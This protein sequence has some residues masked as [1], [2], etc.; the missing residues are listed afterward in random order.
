MPRMKLSA[1][2]T[3]VAP[4]GIALVCAASALA[5]ACSPWSDRPSRAPA[6][7]ELRFVRPSAAEPVLLNEDLVLYFSGEVDR[8]SVTRASIQIRSGSDE[9]RGSLQVDGDRVRFV[10]AP[11]LAPDLSDGGYRPGAE[12]TVAIAGFPEID[13]VRGIRGEPLAHAWTWS[14][15][16]IAAAAGEAA[17]GG[18]VFEDRQPDKIGRLRLV[19]PLTVPQA[20]YSLG[21]QDAIYLACDKPIDPSTLHDDDFE[22]RSLAKD[23]PPIS[24]RA[25]LI[26]NHTIAAPRPRPPEAHS[27][28]SPAQWVRERRAALIELTPKESPASGSWSLVV[29][30]QEL[31][32]AF[33]LRDFS[34]QSVSQGAQRPL[35]IR[36]GAPALRETSIPLDFLDRRMRSPVEVDGADGTAYWND[37]GRVEAR[38]PAAAGN[39]DDGDVVLGEE[40]RRRDVQTTR[41]RLAAGKECVWR[42]SGLAVLRAQGRMSI[43]GKLVRN[44]E[45]RAGSDALLERWQSA[46]DPRKKD[47]EIPTQTLT[48]FLA[49]AAASDVAWTVLVAGG[50]LVIDGELTVNTPLLL[51]AGG[52][53]RVSGAVHGEKGQVFLLREGGG[54]MIDPP[55]APAPSFLRLDPPV[56]KNPLRVPLRLAVM[57]Q[58]IPETGGVS[59]WWPAEAAGSRDGDQHKFNGTWSVRYVSERPSDEKPALPREPAD[60]PL[61]FDPPT[62]LQLQIE[63]VILPGG[64]WDP[65]FVDFVRLSLDPTPALS[66]PAP[67]G[68]RR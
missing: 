49:E 46:N 66:T 61:A 18:F 13:G 29:L 32:H 31:E 14:F 8:A 20:E 17:R 60:S 23:V 41:V 28:S 1:R 52:V 63:L 42:R 2:S 22:L 40:E 65:P 45:A 39:G 15:R 16:T 37:S 6:Q 7:L 12:Y 33:C 48:D 57:S 62:S 51:C 43:A 4:R 68:D 9:A 38:Y 21:P 54:L 34:G 50:D 44:V 64:A 11:V 27:S 25:R 59:R 47:L 26:E 58:P 56:G 3:L 30:P 53:V 19:P 10:P 36:F 24:M 5:A 35:P 67:Q 55:P